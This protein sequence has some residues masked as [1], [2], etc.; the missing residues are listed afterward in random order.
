MLEDTLITL[1]SLIMDSNCFCK[2]DKNVRDS[3]EAKVLT[4]IKG[5]LGGKIFRN[6]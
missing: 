6:S 3:N 4:K 1:C 5:R 2:G